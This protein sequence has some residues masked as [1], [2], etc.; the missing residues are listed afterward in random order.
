MPSDRR[1]LPEKRIGEIFTDLATEI[2]DELLLETF[3]DLHPEVRELANINR[4][5]SDYS[6]KRRAEED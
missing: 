2:E 1:I 3:I 4:N 5:D 6:R